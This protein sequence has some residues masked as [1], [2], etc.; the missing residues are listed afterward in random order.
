MPTFSP[1][2]RAKPVT[3]AGYS[4]G[5]LRTWPAVGFPWWKFDAHPTTGETIMTAFTLF[6]VALSLIGIAA[7]FGVMAG[8]LSAK[9]LNGWAALFLTTTILTSVTGFVFPID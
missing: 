5:C 1:S 8:F 4:V 2:S 7:G 3:V 9:R 6:H